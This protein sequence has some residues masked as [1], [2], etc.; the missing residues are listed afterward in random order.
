M[1]WLWRIFSCFFFKCKA[2]L[3][4]TLKFYPCKFT[5]LLFFYTLTDDDLFM[6]I[7]EYFWQTSLRQ[8]FLFVL[9]HSISLRINTFKFVLT[10]TWWKEHGVFSK[11]KILQ[12]N[13]NRYFFFYLMWTHVC[14]IVKYFAP[15]KHLLQIIS[16][17]AFNLIFS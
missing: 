6:Y 11:L 17:Q 1:F 2:V 9:L 15:V 7:R 8:Y 13:L 16:P 12:S 14:D 3:H 5:N 4:K 10:M